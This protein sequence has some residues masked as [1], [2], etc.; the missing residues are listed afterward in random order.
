MNAWKVACWGTCCGIV[1]VAFC[2]GVATCVC[3][4]AALALLR[5]IRLIFAVLVTAG[6]ED[7]L[8]LSV[9]VA[10]EVGAAAAPRAAARNAAPNSAAAAEAATPVL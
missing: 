7:L 10:E 1:G 3:T 8:L 9:A 5:G 6:E 4:A 2:A